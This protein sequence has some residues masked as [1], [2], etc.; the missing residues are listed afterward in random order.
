MKTTIKVERFAAGGMVLVEKREIA[1]ADRASERATAKAML[2][3]CYCQQPGFD[4]LRVLVDG[5][6][7]DY[8]GVRSSEHLE[9]LYRGLGVP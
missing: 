8:V 1:P 9:S 5:L 3:D 4:P 6:V 7:I 2:A